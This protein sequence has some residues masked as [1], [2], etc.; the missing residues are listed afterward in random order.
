[1]DGSNHEY[2]ICY[3][4]FNQGKV[5]STAGVVAKRHG[6][7]TD[8]CRSDFAEIRIHFPSLECVVCA[9]YLGCFF[10]DS[11]T[12]VLNSYLSSRDV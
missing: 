8:V 2:K 11:K 3:N 9:T 7:I 10:R 1:L 12:M 4:I 6:C 5:A